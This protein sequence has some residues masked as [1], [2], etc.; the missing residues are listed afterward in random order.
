MALDPAPIFSDPSTTGDLRGLFACCRM[1]AI[2]GLYCL[3]SGTAVAD[4]AAA[5]NSAARRV[6]G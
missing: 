1:H 4:L 3:Y 5:N 6:L 2:I